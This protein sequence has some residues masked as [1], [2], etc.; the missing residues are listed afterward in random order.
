MS[1]RVINILVLLVLIGMFGF[2]GYSLASKGDNIGVGDQAV[3][4]DMSNLDGTNTKF[5]DFEGEMVIINFF[6]TWCAPCVD[7]APELEAFVEN[8]GDDYKLIMINRGE[9]KARVKKIIEKYPT[10]AIYLFDPDNKVSKQYNVTGQPETIIIDRQGV[11]R[12]HYN[13]PVSARQ[14]FEMVKKHDK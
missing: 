12:E 13:G 10:P 9:T 3:D 8:Y 14:L 11:V 4:F 5:S 6:A 7:E 1:R 2:F